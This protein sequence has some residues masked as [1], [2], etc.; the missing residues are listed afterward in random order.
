MAGTGSGSRLPT[1]VLTLA[2][3]S[4]F[5]AVLVS[6]M[7]IWLQLRNYRKPALQRMVV[8]IMVMVPLYAISSLIS[9]FSV[10]AAFFID[11]VRD[12]YEAFVIYCF[13]V[14]LLSYLGGERSLLILQ[15]GR[16]PKEPVFPINLFKH[17]IDV[18]DPYTFLFLKRGI[19][20]YVQVKPI[21]AAATFILKVTGKYNE[22]D[23]RANSGYLYISIVYNISICLALYCLAMFWV[24]VNN[25]LKPFR[26]VPKFLC[27][28]GILFFSF[29][30][31]VAISALVAA[32]VIVRLGPYTDPEHISVGLNDLLICIEMPFFAIAHNYAFSYKDFM[33]RN[34][35]FVGR[36]PMY[37]A[38]R[39]SFGLLDLLEDTKTTLRG[40]GMDYREFEPAEGYMHQGAGR[41]RRIRAGLRYS[42]GGQRKYWL[43]K[44]SNDARPPGRT[45]RVLKNAVK[46]VAGDEQAESVHAPLLEQDVDDVVH[47][48]PD[49]QESA[50]D[51]V[52]D[53]P[54]VEDGF[55]LPFGDLDEGDEEL[56]A[57]SKKYLF[58]DYNYPCIDVSSESARTFIWREEERVLRDERGAWF[59]PIRG[60]KGQAAIQSRDRP[61]WE[62][63]G[64]VGNGN[65]YNRASFSQSGKRTGS[66]YDNEDHDNQRL[67][68]HD[69]VRT[70]IA[71][72]PKDVIMKWT[73]TRKT[74]QNGSQPASHSQSP[75]LR[76]TLQPSSTRHTPSSSPHPSSSA[77]GSGSR[78]SPV[79]PPDAVDLVVEDPHAAEE[80]NLRE[81]KKGE[82]TSRGSGLRRVY[83]RGF[84]ASGDDDED[85]R[86]GHTEGEVE[87]EE[88]MNN[89]DG[90][91]RVEAGEEIL[92]TIG[93]DGEDEHPRT[94][95]SEWTRNVEVEGVFARSGT[96]PL[97]ARIQAHQYH[98][99][100]DDGNP[101]AS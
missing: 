90:S 7:S 44:A 59:S 24:C 88:T 6:M 83:R 58:G 47:L 97:H 92:H 38:F 4:T 27:V 57:H 79:L 43:P 81:R 80:E 66:F 96:P 13:F 26:P 63:Y 55:E 69:D 91:R 74:R 99:I 21:L 93:D 77:S 49:M 64:A 84:V 76:P 23:F 53:N 35:S 9:L 8:R 30:Q 36:M 75:H 5:I 72:E 39:D 15:H 19:L 68:D 25:D 42:K 2:G 45:E 17:E 82:P 65:A 48:A 98:D 3:I 62:G 12:I 41:D 28:K 51:S 71:A 54:H 33:D 34:H 14:L 29:W 73:K 18:S 32:R 89:D 46:R 56:F 22:G 20:Q 70:A 10:E 100:P 86:E 101:W 16:P 67:I 61:A 11:A 87:V 40:E 85:D 60:A 95:G 50:E 94:F 78:P 37:Y 31:S 52:W 1:T